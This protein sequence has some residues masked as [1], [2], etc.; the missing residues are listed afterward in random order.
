MSNKLRL[1]KK[2][3]KSQQ[4]ELL[5]G[6]AEN[7][8]KI[9]Y[10]HPVSES[11]LKETLPPTGKQFNKKTVDSKSKMQAVLISQQVNTE[12]FTFQEP[13]DKYKLN[14]TRHIMN[15]I[16]VFKLN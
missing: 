9:S 13:R 10:F 11:R 1:K 7:E 12:N 5:K 6:N 3:D 4:R 8:A 16:D 2:N 15:A 14:K